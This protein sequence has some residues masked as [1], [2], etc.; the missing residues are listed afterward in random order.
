MSEPKP[1]EP[2]PAEPAK[3]D[4]LKAVAASIDGYVFKFPCKGTM[5]ETPKKGADADSALVPAG[6][7]PKKQDNFAADKTFGGTKG[8][9]YLVTLRFRGV[10]EPMK[11][12]NGKMD[13][14]YFYVG[15][16]PDNGT[17]NI[18]KIAVSSPESHFF[19]NRQDAVGH[20]IF[21]IDYTKTIEIEG[22]S[23]VKFTGD[24]QNGRLISNFEKLVVPDVSPEIKQPFHGQ[25]VQ[26]DVVDVVEKK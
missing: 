5:P 6:G 20:R 10:V 15:G 4:N 19:L 22:Q 2:K 14:D 25:F 9:H 1:A 23:T 8:K 12:K 13:G 26:V 17:Y 18:Y 11:Y 16:E 24:G 21:K 7:D 3:A